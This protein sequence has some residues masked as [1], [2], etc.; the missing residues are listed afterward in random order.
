MNPVE[1]EP[2]A[3]EGQA[4]GLRAGERCGG[5]GNR[6]QRRG[7]N[8]EPVV[9]PRGNVSMIF[10][11]REEREVA[12]QIGRKALYIIRASSSSSEGS[13]S[14]KR[15][16]SNMLVEGWTRGREGQCGV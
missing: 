13:A 3:V 9:V 11:R 8:L 5:V 6:G 10:G 14:R 16:S 1:G 12:H 15:R 7:E 4:M 2:G